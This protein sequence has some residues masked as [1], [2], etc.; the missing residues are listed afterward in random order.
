MMSVEE[1]KIK[2]DVD[3][4]VER[5]AKLRTASVDV[6]TSFVIHVG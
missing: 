1:H 3:V 2:F 4:D 6:Q 5:P